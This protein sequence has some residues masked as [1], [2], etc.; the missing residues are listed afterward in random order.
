M[1]GVW[2]CRFDLS[3]SEASSQEK[4]RA[5]RFLPLS[6]RPLH[7]E[8]F[9]CLEGRLELEYKKGGLC[10]M[11]GPGILLLS[12]CSSLRRC[13]CSEELKGLLIAVDAKAARESLFTVCSVLGMKLDTGIVRKRMKE[14]DG[15][16]ILSSMPW[17]EALFD[18]MKSL[19]EKTQNRYCVFKAVELLYLLCAEGFSVTKKEPRGSGCA[20][21]L[22]LEI[23]E[24]MLT[25]L[26]EKITIERLSRQFSISPTS[27]KE[28]FRLSFGLPV[29]RWLIEQRL[30]RARELL[31]TT[32]LSVWEVAQSVG[33]EGMSQF[34]A[35]F[36]RKF[37]LT[38]GQQ[39]K[40][41][42][43]ATSRLF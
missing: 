17:V 32:R 41:S 26:S 12:D 35:A 27:L 9:Y 28:G 40:M 5:L 38:P 33:Y 31:C 24:Y 25:H 18:A 37:G 6:L 23:R 22:M 43:T 11:Q 19:D 14:L 30:S 8:V 3:E 10:E 36:K 29:H 16:I 13:R 39:R 34:N 4:K 20:S 21:S 7:F 1:P 2:I 15:S 42:K